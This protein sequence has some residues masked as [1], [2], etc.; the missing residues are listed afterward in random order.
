VSARTID[1]DLRAAAA[2][3]PDKPVVVTPD[4]SLSYREL[5][6]AADRVACGLREL[7]VRPGDRVGLVLPNTAELPEAI[8]GVLRAGAAF[9][10]LNPTIK[11]H[12]LAQL[13]DHAGAAAVICDVE[14]TAVTRPAAAGA[15]DIPVIDDL[16]SLAGPEEPR[17]QA[18]LDADLAAVI[19][20]S[21]STGDPKGVTVTHR[22]MSF[23]ADSIVEYLEMDGEDRILCVL[24]LSFGYGLYQLLTCVRARATL[25]LEPGFSFPGRVV[26]VLEQERITGLAGVP[27]VFQVLISLR[28]LA[29]R[30]LPHLR[31]LTNAGAALP[32]ATI[33][34]VR[35]TFPGARLYSMYGQTE[36]TRVCYLPPEQ[37]DVRP[38]S[39]G[40]AIPGTQAWVED[41]E[42][43]VAAAGEVGELMVRG[44]HVMQGYW[45]DPE[46]TAE[47]LRPGPW[48]WDRVLATGDLFSQDAE[49]FLY[50]VGRRDDLIKSRGEK[51]A[52][53]E[54]EEV[55][56]AIP[57]VREVAVVGAAD[58]LLG[59][60]V[61]A[62]VAPESGRELDGDE[63]RRHCAEQLEL[64]KVPQRVIFH[65]ALPRTANG[66]ID[67]A[68]L[69]GG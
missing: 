25:V 66:K 56:H 26:G 10:P 59:Q 46:G 65:T 11:Q 40:I 55:L 16:A 15:G 43:R 53:R 64:H 14:R 50:F 1:G 57:G 8:Y 18:P 68:A 42:G 6:H 30:A 4:R 41:D 51:V 7:G 29:D 37:L 49:G 60:A 9:T 61:H 58:T 52:P 36:C 20:T 5:D 48:P 3:Q 35:D 17:L 33:A 32:A 31:L 28:G 21:G 13:L 2:G 34:Q 24:P 54:V 69:L 45:K 27:T 47:R 62:H 22:N 67:R 38:T 23:V 39:V 63:L 19:Y 12:K 44:S